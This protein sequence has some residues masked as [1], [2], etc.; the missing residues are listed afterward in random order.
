[1]AQPLSQGHARLGPVVGFGV[2]ASLAIVSPA[3]AALSFTFD[4]ASARPGTTVA[5][6]EPGWPSAPTGV[7][8]Y[9]VPTRLRGVKPDPAGGYILR[10]PPKRDIVK[11]GRPRLTRE[12]LLT[13]R[14]R[15]PKVRPGNYTTAFWCRTCAQGGDFFASA[16]WGAPWTGS[17]GT[18]LRITR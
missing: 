7:T 5:A 14:F 18:V 4:R 17:P 2:L 11:L 13:I 1:M 15:V 9:L 12:H 10:R 8:V 6:S 3:G 16:L